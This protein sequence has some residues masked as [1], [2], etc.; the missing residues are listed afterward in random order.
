MFPEFCSHYQVNK[1]LQKNP[2]YLSLKKIT[3][4]TPL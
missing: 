2:D 4:F 3:S 1:Y